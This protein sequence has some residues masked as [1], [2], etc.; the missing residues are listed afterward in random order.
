MKKSNFK[1]NLGDIVRVRGLENGKNLRMIT[2]RIENFE[3]TRAGEKRG[4][5]G[6][7]CRY[8]CEYPDYDC[9]DTD[10]YGCRTFSDEELELVSSKS[11]S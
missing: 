3:H 7:I 5:N 10:R 9:E 1:F 2:A 6:V 8:L 11:E 4:A